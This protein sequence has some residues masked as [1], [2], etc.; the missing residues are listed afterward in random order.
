VNLD[1]RL[2]FGFLILV[3]VW[4]SF[5]T[6]LIGQ[7]ESKAP[8]WVFHLC[9]A[10]DLSLASCS[11]D[12]AFYSPVT[13]FF[14]FAFQRAGLSASVFYAGWLALL[15]GLTAYLL[16]KHGGEVALYVYFAVLPLFT[17]F[18]LRK[19]LYVWMNLVY[20]GLVPFTT[21]LVLSFWLLLEWKT[22]GWKRGPIFLFALVVHQWAWVF[23][24]V[25]ILSLVIAD[26]FRRSW[27]ALIAPMVLS[28]FASW[29][30]AGI[31]GGVDSA[32]RFAALFFLCVS[33]ILSWVLKKVGE[34]NFSLREALN[35]V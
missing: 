6:A 17:V 35:A 23:L 20:T 30:F 4:M 22:L 28:V 32:Y 18:V 10:K 7:T 29:F 31:P 8:D 34:K 25:I 3:V 9:Y 12:Y 15:M 11:Q 24:S 13:A 26:V 21:L 2:V 33:V 16:L 5:E 14:A 27:L 19:A 1:K